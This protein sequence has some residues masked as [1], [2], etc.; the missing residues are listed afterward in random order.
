MANSKACKIREIARSGILALAVIAASHVA[1]AQHHEPAE[2]QPAQ[3]RSETGPIPLGIS[4]NALMVAA[5]DHSAHVIWEGET[6][7]SLSDHDWQVLEQHALMLIGTGTLMSLPG[8]GPSDQ[9]WVADPEWQA[10]SREYTDSA[11][12]ALA[13]VKSMDQDALAAAGDALVETCNGCH[14]AFRPDMATEGI[15]HV[16]HYEQL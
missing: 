4:M 16:P 9:K 11:H 14:Q 15:A 6:E 12:A 2:N 3:S 7:S 10:W 13:A 8:N 1:L 5:V